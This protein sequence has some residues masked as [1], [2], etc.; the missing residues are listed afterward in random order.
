MSLLQHYNQLANNHQTGNVIFSPVK[1]ILL[2]PSNNTISAIDL[3]SYN[4]I[5][6]KTLTRFDITIQEIS[7]C[8]K[9]LAVVDASNKIYILSLIKNGL[10]L[11]T[12]QVSRKFGQ[13][14]IKMIKFSK[15]GQLAVASNNVLIL[16]DIPCI[17]DIKLLT[18]NCIKLIKVYSEMKSDSPIS[19]LNF[20]DEGSKLLVGNESGQS[21]ILSAVRL[22]GGKKSR[23]ILTRLMGNDRGKIVYGHILKDGQ[24]L[25][26]ASNKNCR[27]FS[28]NF[29]LDSESEGEE[30]QTE[31]MDVKDETKADGQANPPTHIRLKKITSIQYVNLSH[32]G[33]P[34]KEERQAAYENG[35]FSQ[36][37]TYDLVKK[38]RILSDSNLA[39]EITSCSFNEKN[40]LIAV[41]LKDGSFSLLDFPDFCLINWE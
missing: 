8:G 6:L 41:G 27:I 15:T 18:P 32:I 38:E 36:I 5:C 4:T 14:E 20:N 12:Y 17:R 21:L 33:N 22:N 26:I 2:I 10:L 1:D 13:S 19:C 9:F 7:P 3:V 35:D 34:N 31:A 16:Y 11:G 30:D 25:T 28:E 39:S 29:N 40:K 24:V 23:L 37:L